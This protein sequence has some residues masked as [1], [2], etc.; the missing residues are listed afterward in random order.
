MKRIAVT[1]ENGEIYQHFGKTQCFT[2]YTIE[3]G[4]VADKKLLDTSDSGHSALAGVLKQAGA[5]LLICGGIGAGARL[6]LEE[7]GIRLYPGAAGSA[8]EAVHAFLAGTLQYQPDLVC[9]HHRDA[10]P[11]VCGSHTCSAACYHER[12]EKACHEPN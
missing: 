4:K 2:L 7:A 1:T 10:P 6:A 12:Q 11:R 3:D 5:E 9:S 8:D